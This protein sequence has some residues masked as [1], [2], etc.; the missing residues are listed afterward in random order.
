[1]KF[2]LSSVVLLSSVVGGLAAPAARGGGGENNNNNNNSNN[3]NNSDNSNNSSNNNNINNNGGGNNGVTGNAARATGTVGATQTANQAGAPAVAVKSLA[4]A[5]ANWAKD[6]AVVS[7]FLNLAPTLEGQAFVN[8][9]K[10]HWTPNLMNSFTKLF[11]MQ[12]QQFL[13]AQMSREQTILW[14]LKENSRMLS[15]C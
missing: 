9:L 6:T 15:I 5:A 10:L 4:S 14:L 12:I 2:S 11:S 7:N 13:V 1:M 8:K 3:G